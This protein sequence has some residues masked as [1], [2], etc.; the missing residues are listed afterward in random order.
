MTPSCKNDPLK[1]QIFKNDPLKKEKSF[2]FRKGFIWSI[3]GEESEK[4]VKNDF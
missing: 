3:N 1:W 2:F 4:M